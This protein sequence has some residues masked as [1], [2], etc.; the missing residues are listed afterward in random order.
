M[1]YCE[2]LEKKIRTTFKKVNLYS[3]IHFDSFKKGTVI[4]SEFQKFIKILSKDFDSVNGIDLITHQIKKI[5]D[6]IDSKNW[7]TILN[8]KTTVE[9]ELKILGIKINLPS[10]NEKAQK[11]IHEWQKELNSK[12]YEKADQLRNELKELFIL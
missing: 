12:N 10:I 1:T 5:N 4:D 6:Q 7:N 2:K 9:K 8:Q 11:T 3:F